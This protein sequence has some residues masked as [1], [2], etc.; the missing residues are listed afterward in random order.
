MLTVCN[1]I[2]VLGGWYYT[3]ILSSERCRGMTTI[4][5]CTVFCCGLGLFCVFTG[6]GNGCVLYVDYLQPSL[7]PSAG[8]AP[9]HPLHTGRHWEAE[10]LRGGLRVQSWSM[11][12]CFLCYWC[13]TLVFLGWQ[14]FSLSN[15]VSKRKRGCVYL[16]ASQWSKSVIFFYFIFFFPPQFLSSPTALSPATPSQADMKESKCIQP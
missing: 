12:G 8:A 15:H 13:R 2:Y 16:I 7:E 10:R 3:W 11:S 14:L 5:R 4:P 6:F 9:L 1:F